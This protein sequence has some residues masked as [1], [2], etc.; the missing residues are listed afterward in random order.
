[1]WTCHNC[2]NQNEEN[3]NFCW[4]CGKPRTF[5]N[6]AEHE[7]D[8]DIP[9]S[10]PMDFDLES[11]ISQVATPPKVERPKKLERKEPEMVVIKPIKHE[12]AKIP[13]KKEEIKEEILHEPENI[14]EK[15]VEIA[16]ESEVIKHKIPE[17]ELFST[18]L[19]ESE[20]RNATDSEANWE[21]VGFTIAVRVVGLYFI[22]LIL[23]SIPHFISL[24]YSFFLLENVQIK[25]FG[26][27]LA[28]PLFILTAKLLFYLVLG[29]YL[30]SSGR[31]LIWLL[32]TAYSK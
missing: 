6:E 11:N 5:K 21:N 14:P 15:K 29:I 17:P 9:V 31:L 32:P 28:I 20:R 19:P 4:S 30:I 22:F 10:K 16:N 1:M 23:I 25:G 18:F 24:A 12:T 13:V 27:L 2:E 8:T 3:F 7:L 26:D